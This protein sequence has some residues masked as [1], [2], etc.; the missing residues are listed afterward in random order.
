MAK[1]SLMEL[2]EAG[3]LSETEELTLLRRAHDHHQKQQIAE[4]IRQQDLQEAKIIRL[5]R[6]WFVTAAASILLAMVGWWIFAPKNQSPLTPQ[7]AIAQVAAPKSLD[8]H[9]MGSDT[10]KTISDAT[11]AFETAYRNRNYAQAVLLENQISLADKDVL[12]MLGYS[13]LQLGRYPESIRVFKQLYDIPYAPQDNARW[14]LGL[15]HGLAGDQTNMR[16]YLQAIPKGEYQYEAA[17]RL[18]K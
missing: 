8:H 11:K 6:N 15:A 7:Q 2:Y 1:K 9:M 17:Q 3:E 13:Y 10:K 16:L 12:A 4:I 5:R 14:W 18:L